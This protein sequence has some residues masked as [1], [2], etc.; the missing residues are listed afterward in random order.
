MCPIIT[1]RKL[2]ASQVSDDFLETI[3]FMDD[4]LWCD[5]T[6]ETL[7]LGS[8]S[9]EQEPT[10]LR[11]KVIV[12]GV[13]HPLHDLRLVRLV[14]AVRAYRNVNAV[15]VY[16]ADDDWRIVIEP[17]LPIVYLSDLDGDALVSSEAATPD[18]FG[19]LA[20]GQSVVADLFPAE[21]SV[22]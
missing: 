14:L 6:A 17:D 15:S 19:R 8:L 2:S 7:D 13:A 9:L 5:S 12:T 18:D 21:A 1:N 22:A 3:E 11:S 20:A 10:G 16:A 4:Q